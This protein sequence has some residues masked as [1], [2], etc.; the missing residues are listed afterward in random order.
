MERALDPALLAG[1]L[2][3]LESL[4][5]PE[6]LRRLLAFA[7][8]NAFFAGESAIER[9][10]MD[11]AWTLHQVGTV[12]PALQIYGIDRQIQANSVAAHIFDLALQRGLQAGD[13]LV[14]TFAAQVSSIRGDRTPNASAIGARLPR[15]TSSVVIDPGRAALEV[16]CA[17]LSLGRADTVELLRRLEAEL[18]TV[19]AGA[20]VDFAGTH[21]AAAVAVVRGCRLLLRYLTFGDAQNLEA[22]RSRFLAGANDPASRRDLDS[23]WVCSHLLDLT[24]DLGGSSVWAIVPP[25][26]P[27]PV[28]MTMTLGEPPVLALWPPQISLL[29][30]SEHSPLR[31]DVRRAVLT[32]PTSAGKTLLTQLVIA[33]HLTTVNTPVCVVAPSH[34]LCREIRQGLDR[35]LWVLRKFIAEDGPIGDP[36]LARAPVVVMTP[37]RLAARLRTSSTELLD[38]FGLF[39]LDEAHLGDC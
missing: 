1:A 23:R 10:L 13:A 39:V 20:S 26:T 31:T 7:E 21:L 4:P 36:N 2:G 22:A 5:S 11:T 35:R 17:F 32:F 8:V 6:E 30:D 37:E 15:S 27:R 24:D 16:G 28:A 12:R 9:Q 19:D 3:D 25:D 38:Q 14:T 33:H 29:S 34:S 18:R